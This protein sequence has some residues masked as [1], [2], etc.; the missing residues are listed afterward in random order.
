MLL[1]TNQFHVIEQSS[2]LNLKANEQT[3]NLKQSLTKRKAISGAQAGVAM[4]VVVVTAV[5]SGPL[6]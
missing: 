1:Y 4:E 3:G 5:L 2:W 6:V